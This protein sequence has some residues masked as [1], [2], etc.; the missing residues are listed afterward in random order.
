MKCS[1]HPSEDSVGVCEKCGAGLC[2]HCFNATEYVS[3][4]GK[5]LCRSCNLQLMHDMLAEEKKNAIKN[6]IK[7]IFFG[8][9]VGIGV[10]ALFSDPGSN[11]VVSYF[12]IAGIG[13]L[14]T[15]WKM[16]ANSAKEDVRE[17]VAEAHGDFSYTFM[18]LIIRI[19]LAFVFGGIGAPFVLL[20]G[21]IRFLKA[22][23]R[24]AKLQ[25]QIEEFQS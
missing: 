9:C 16:T 13:C 3:A 22:R 4:S 19:V 21:V 14:P 7:V 11:G 23:V 24:I 25:K 1:L 6:L 2:Q 5:H 20:F 10:Y 15:T 17:A 18:G 8:L 12:F